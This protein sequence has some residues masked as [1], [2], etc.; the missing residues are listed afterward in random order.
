MMS[1]HKPENRAPEMTPQAPQQGQPAGKRKSD[2]A[3]PE[4]IRQFQM[5]S[6]KNPDDF[7]D[8]EDR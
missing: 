7:D 6:N 5:Q 8:E 1:A 2:A 3:S 4:E